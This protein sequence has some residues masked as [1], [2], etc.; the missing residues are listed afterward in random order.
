MVGALEHVDAAFSGNYRGRS[1]FSLLGVGFN[2]AEKFALCSLTTHD[3]LSYTIH[4][5]IFNFGFLPE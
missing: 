3:E 2:P 5:A 4:Y 1:G